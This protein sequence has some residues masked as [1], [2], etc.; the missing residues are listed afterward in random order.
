[1]KQLLLNTTILLIML[2]M[3]SLNASAYDLEVNGIYY[4]ITS[5][6]QRTVEV[7]SGSAYSGSV[8]IPKNVSYDGVTYSVTSIGAWAFYGSSGLAFV[9]I[10]N[11]VT[12]L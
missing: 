10:P 4:N 5:S 3:V 11:S 12:T 8:V 9:E 2:S 6:V 1:M 7:T